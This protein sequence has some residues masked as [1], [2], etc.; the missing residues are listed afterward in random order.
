VERICEP[1]NNNQISGGVCQGERTFYREALVVN[2]KVRRS[3]GSPRR[4]LFLAE[5]ISLCV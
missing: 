4:T 3:G 5:E 1:I 2:E